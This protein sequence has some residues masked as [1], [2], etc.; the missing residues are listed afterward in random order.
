MFFITSLLPVQAFAALGYMLLHSIWQISLLALLAAAGMRLLRYSTAQRRYQVL[1]LCLHLM[2][3]SAVG[4]LFYY[5][6]QEQTLGKAMQ[7]TNTF[8]SVPTDSS[9]PASPAAWTYLEGYVQQVLPLLARGWLLGVSLLLLRLLYN[10]HN[11]QRLRYR[12]LE[13]PAKHYVQLT[14]RLARAMGI[15]RRVHTYISSRI[16]MPMTIGWLSPIILLPVGAYIQLSQKEMEAVLVHELAHIKRYDYLINLLQAFVEVL[17]FYHPALWWL[18]QRIRTEREHCCDDRVLAWYPDRMLYAKAL[19]RLQE[20]GGRS[21][22]LALSVAANRH[23]LLLRIQRILNQP[24]NRNKNMEKTTAIGLILAAMLLF[25]LSNYEPAQEL[26]TLH[27]SSGFKE[28]ALSQDTVPRG[29]RTFTIVQ[30]DTR[31]EGEVDEEGHLQQLSINGTSVSEAD[32]P[33]YQDLM[34][35]YLSAIPAS[36]PAPP[37]PRTKTPPMPPTPPAPPAP[38]V[39]DE[40]MIDAILKKRR[41]LGALELTLDDYL[42]SEA[43]L[44][45]LVR[46]STEQALRMAELS[47]EQRTTLER[48]LE[49]ELQR[50]INEDQLREQIQQQRQELQEQMKSKQ[51]EVMEQIERSMQSQEAAFEQL[52]QELEQKNVLM[53]EVQRRLKQEGLINRIYEQIAITDEQLVLG[54]KKQSGEVY[55][56]F[57]E[58][59]EEFQKQRSVREE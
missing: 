57:I 5:L 48:A 19:L 6:R 29:D 13:T 56:R 47:E 11:A 38:A 20:I 15:S 21:P 42:L 51:S 58:L 37:A 36:P 26:A 32:L 1:Q 43:Q 49:E 2:L 10:L 33:Q 41:G 24:Q 53:D 39:P 44:D 40:E 14:D 34:Q 9:L 18:S 50:R 3:L 4:T 23:Q 12:G 28:A 35:K 17:F 27:S 45:S 25:S 16:S 59:M 55:R 46:E 54:Q 31:I 7:Q 30:H 52:R 8:I 22:V